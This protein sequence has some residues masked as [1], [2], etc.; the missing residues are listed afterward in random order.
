MMVRAET[1]KRNP[2]SAARRPY[3]G[4]ASGSRMTIVMWT[5]A[6][7]VPQPSMARSAGSRQAEDEVTVVARPRRGPSEG[8]TTPMMT[9]HAR[10]VS[11][12]TTNN[13]RRS[14]RPTLAAISPA[15]IPAAARAAF[16]RL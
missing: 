3:A 8:M 16:S 2:A 13:H 1:V 9:A 11:A 10:Q 4:R 6:R 15:P 14:H 7:S 5:R 12:S